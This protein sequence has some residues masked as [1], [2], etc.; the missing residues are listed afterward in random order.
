M[1]EFFPSFHSPR[2]V[3]TGMSPDSPRLMDFA[4]ESVLGCLRCG[5]RVF[6]LSD[7]SAYRVIVESE[8]YQPHD[9]LVAALLRESAYRH[10]W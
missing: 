6:R 1:M 5:G 8:D 9:S 7:D 2:S 4:T 10:L 3:L